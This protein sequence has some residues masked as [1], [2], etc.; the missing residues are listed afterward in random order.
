MDCKIHALRVLSLTGS[1]RSVSCVRGIPLGRFPS[2][3]LLHA[4][5]SHFRAMK[6]ILRFEN[7]IPE[8]GHIGVNGDPLANAAILRARRLLGSVLSRCGTGL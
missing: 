2:R 5:L 1:T 4:N 6:R 7:A 8:V 3:R